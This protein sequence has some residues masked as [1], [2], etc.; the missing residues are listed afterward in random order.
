MPALT[1]PSWEYVARRGAHRASGARTARFWELLSPRAG[2]EH[3]VSGV[4]VLPRSR[5]AREA[6]PAGHCRS[7]SPGACG[8]GSFGS[9]PT[10]PRS[11]GRRG[12]VCPPSGGPTRQAEPGRSSEGRTNPGVPR[13]QGRSPGPVCWSPVL[14]VARVD[15]GRT[16]AVPH[17]PRTSPSPWSTPVAAGRR[18]P[19]AAARAIKKRRTL[20]AVSQLF[21]R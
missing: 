14:S 8:T 1:L 5:R 21:K 18:R 7:G 19:C 17:G 3:G 15:E 16:S 20:Q 9:V 10:W 11:R 2:R 13:R 6:C 4:P 12:P